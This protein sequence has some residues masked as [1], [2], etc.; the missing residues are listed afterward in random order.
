MQIKTGP[1]DRSGLGPI[2]LLED[3][4]LIALDFELFLQGEGHQVL[5]PFR[6]SRQALE[7]LETLA[8]GAAI[9]DAHLGGETSGPVARALRDR[10][11]PF[12]Y[13]TGGRLDFAG[14]GLPPAPVLH[15]PVNLREMLSALHGLVGVV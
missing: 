14:T 3:E 5:G 13:V 2:L 9:L 15:K 10:G 7:A 4:S 8:P 12:L 6:T 11:I 1:E